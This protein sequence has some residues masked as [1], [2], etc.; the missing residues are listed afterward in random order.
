MAAVTAV[1]FDA[2]GTLWDFEKVMRDA[3]AVTLR[4][5]R[6]RHPG[7]ATSRLTVEEMVAIRD[8][9]AAD[10]QHDWVRLEDIRLAAFTATVQRV[11]LDDPGLAPG[12]NALY[13][14]HRFADIELYSDVLNCLDAVAR[15]HTVGL[16][17]NGNS[18]P[19]RCGLDARFAFTVFAEQHGVAKPDP[20]IFEIAA[21]A[22]GCPVEELVHVGD[23]ES[24]IIGARR[25]GCRAVLINR[26][27]TD[28][29]YAAQADGEIHDLRALP[30]VLNE[31]PQAG[32]HNK[33]ATR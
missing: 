32:G 17:S 30:G 24:D 25:A 21:E 3:L 7:P 13:L 26:T 20:A 33:S 11:G 2:D 27:G 14:R 12:L 6:R 28:L 10:Y 18:Y 23:G 31:M 16:L 19:E 4:D 1:S 8:E 22:A 9:V 15:D 5:L 29:P